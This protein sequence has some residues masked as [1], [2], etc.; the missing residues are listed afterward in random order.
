[1][2]AGQQGSGEG[3]SHAEAQYEV[4]GQ[5]WTLPSYNNQKKMNI[6]MYISMKRKS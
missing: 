2:C 5:V 3:D 4:I 1:M 6:R